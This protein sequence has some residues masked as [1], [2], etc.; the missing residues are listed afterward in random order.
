MLICSAFLSAKHFHFCIKANKR[1]LSPHGTN[2]NVSQ[3]GILGFWLALRPFT[4][5]RGRCT[6]VCSET[7]PEDFGA[8][9]LL[10]EGCWGS[11]TIPIP[12]FWVVSDY[13]SPSKSLCSKPLTKTC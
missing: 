9:A 6:L 13:P 12:K 2:P 5:G 1:Q 4:L 11:V 10:G 3:N 7:A 8:T